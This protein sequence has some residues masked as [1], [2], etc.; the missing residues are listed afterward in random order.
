MKR[1]LSCIALSLTFFILFT[2][3]KTA[4]QTAPV[5]L[6]DKTFGGDDWDLMYGI[7]P[8]AD[9][10]YLLV[11]NS[12]SGISG[13]KTEPTRSPNTGDYWV[14][15]MSASGA[16][17]WDKTYGG[18]AGDFL[19]TAIATSDGG[20]LLGGVSYSDISGEKSQPCKGSYDY[21]IIKIDASGNKLW[22]KTIGGSW[23]D[24]LYAITPTPDGGFLL[25]GHSKS[26]ISGDR[27]VA[28]LGSYD[29]WLVKI[30]ASGNKQWDKA[31]G[32]IWEDHLQTIMIAA[33]GSYLLFGHSNSPIGGSKT[34]ASNG[35]ADYWV[36]KTDASGN[37][38]W[39]K[40]YGGSDAE[41]LFSVV[42]TTD[43]GYLLGGQSAS[44]ISG[45]KTEANRG[46]NDYWIVKI[47]ASGN[48]LWDKTYGGNNE[49]ILRTLLLTNDGGFLLGGDS[50]SG[51]SGD[52]TQLNQ[53]VEDY[54]L[55]KTDA[56]G[57]KQWDKTIGGNHDEYLYSLVA[58]SDEG[59]L[60]AGY[61]SSTT[62]TGDKTAPAKGSDDFWVVKL[63]TP[64]TVSTGALNATKFCSGKPI[65][66]PFTT[67]GPFTSGNVFTAQLSNYS[68]SF[69]SPVNIGTLSSTGP[70]GVINATIPAGTLEG[71]Y[72]RVRVVASNPGIVGND[73]G[74]DLHITPTPTAQVNGTLVY[75]QGD[76]LFLTATTSLLY[77][78]SW[79]G[80]NG[81]S[82]N[83]DYANIFKVTAANAGNYDLTVTQNG[84]SASTSATVVVNSL[85]LAYT[86][87][88][89]TVC[90]GAPVPLGAAAASGHTYSWTSVAAGFTSSLANPTVNPTANTTYTLTETITGTT[91]SKT[92]SVLV[93]ALPIP[94]TPA[95]LPVANAPTTFCQGGLVTLGSSASTGARWYKDGLII[96]NA[97]QLDY[98][99]T[100]SGVYT[101][102]TTLLGCTSTPSAGITVTV[103][104]LPAVPAITATGNVLTSSA[105][106]GNQW[107]VNGNIITGATGQTYT[108]TAS[109]TY[110]VEVTLNGCSRSSL[111]FTHTITGIVSPAAW[112]GEVVV[113]PNPASKSLFVKNTGIRK[114]QLELIDLFG[115]KVYAGNLSIST[116]TID[117]RGLA[118]GIYQLRATDLLKKETI[119]LTVVKQQ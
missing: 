114:L 75:C 43:G 6:W 52:K 71:N 70:S 96:S 76:N 35:G 7:V 115:R 33:D 81:F 36:I 111:P 57:N 9:G 1:T 95:I 65:D 79:A 12:L 22:D 59:Y 2:V 58:T 11:G 51:I 29:Y 97:V 117:L 87:N 13:D 112:N 56:S 31:F 40:T 19:Q 49:D 73:N 89:T 38:L 10:N 41:N 100:T 39:E 25:G 86:G 20:F 34:L 8:A 110:A 83:T 17:L 62:G 68:G 103:K 99:A 63:G 94:P 113:Y 50:R 42:A 78:Y 4:A 101:T 21:W 23:D 91:C 60:L 84:C 27:T 102:T 28:N 90:S 80:P 47:D 46:L 108:A 92:K 67:A 24:N 77:S 55:I 16:K 53:G 107:Y 5:K 37:K 48:K 105:A 106:T 3:T 54:W 26:D 18:S 66:V 118:N 44:G 14:V 15:K 109:G 74:T 45:D 88:D 116:G 85:P 93:N 82:I 64:T 30:D 32:G 98:T 69:T 119:V 104:S 72:Y 61:G